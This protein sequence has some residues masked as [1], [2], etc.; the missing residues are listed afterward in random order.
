MHISTLCLS[1]TLSY[2]KYLFI[3][4][5]HIISPAKHDY[6]SAFYVLAF[7]APG[8]GDFTHEYFPVAIFPVEQFK[9]LSA[10]EGTVHTDW[11]SAVNTNLATVDYKKAR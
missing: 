2:F 6:Y 5:R 8:S 4:L 9:T 10:A 3:A 11:E 7:A 1:V